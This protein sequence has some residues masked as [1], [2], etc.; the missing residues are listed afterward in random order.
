[1]HTTEEFFYVKHVEDA[2]TCI[3]A[4]IGRN[5]MKPSWKYQVFMKQSQYLMQVSHVER[6]APCI[7]HP[8]VVKRL[9]NFE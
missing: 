1:M 2:S 7:V 5:Y 3:Y 8:I 4:M 9:H 6:R